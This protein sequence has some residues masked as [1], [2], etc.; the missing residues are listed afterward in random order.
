[1]AVAAVHGLDYALTWLRPFANAVI[2]SGLE[3]ACREQGYQPPIICTPE[4]LTE[5]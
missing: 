2:R 3:R 5:D 4:E 1:V